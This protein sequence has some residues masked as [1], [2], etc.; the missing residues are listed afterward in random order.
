[1]LFLTEG[2]AVNNDV[3]VGSFVAFIESR[4]GTCRGFV[5][6]TVTRITPSYVYIDAG[7]NEIIRKTPEKVKKLR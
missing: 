4:F 2:M 7:E 3:E 1:M 5:T 6:G